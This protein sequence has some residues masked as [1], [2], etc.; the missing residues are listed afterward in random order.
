MG[1]LRELKEL[2][3]VE[4]LNCVWLKVKGL[5]VIVTTIGESHA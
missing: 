4:H 1:L 3:Y 5:A 2:I